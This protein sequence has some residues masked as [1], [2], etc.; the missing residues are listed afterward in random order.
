M[1][2]QRRTEKYED[3][4]GAKVFAASKLGAFRYETPA[5]VSD[6]IIKLFSYL[7]EELVDSSDDPNRQ[8]PSLNNGFNKD[9]LMAA[10]ADEG[11]YLEVF[12]GFCPLGVLR[13]H[14]G[15]FSPVGVIVTN[16]DGA[17]PRLNKYSIKRK[18]AGS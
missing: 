9:E 14:L 4:L 7:D 12:D 11:K 5:D 6:K 18:S 10:L 16:A 8:T 1:P 15:K 3:I 13:P 2:K 17:S